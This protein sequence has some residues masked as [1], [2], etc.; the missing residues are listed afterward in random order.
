[1][2]Y[3]TWHRAAPPTSEAMVSA[4]P[5]SETRMSEVVKMA[6][7]AQRAAMTPSFWS[8]PSKEVCC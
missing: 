2:K 1:M 3:S 5:T 4:H 7:L 6:A 8:R